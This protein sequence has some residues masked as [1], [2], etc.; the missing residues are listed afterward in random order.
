MLILLL[1][2]I[3]FVVVQILRTQNLLVPLHQRIQEAARNVATCDNKR[4]RVVKIALDAARGYADHERD[5]HE[6][7]SKDFNS[8]PPAQ[9][10]SLTYISHLVNTFPQLRASETYM[11][12]MHELVRI[13]SEFQEKLEEHNARVRDYNSVRG[14]FPNDLFG[15]LRGFGLASHLDSSDYESDDSEDTPIGPSTYPQVGMRIREKSGKVLEIVSVSEKEV[16]SVR[17]PQPGKST[18]GWIDRNEDIDFWQDRSQREFTESTS[19][20][21]ALQRTPLVLLLPP[22]D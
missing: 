9:R 6:R 20:N 10:K 2:A 11:S 3:V 7:I 21:N 16:K 1:I 12:A 15:A 17:Y 18:P 4:D 19:S 5:L 22:A 8:T 13:E 14:S